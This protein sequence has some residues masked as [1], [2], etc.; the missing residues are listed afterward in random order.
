[1]LGFVHIWTQK[2]NKCFSL[3]ISQLVNYVSKIQQTLL[4]VDMKQSYTVDR[5]NLLYNKSFIYVFCFEVK[6]Y[7]ILRTQTYVAEVLVYAM[8]TEIFFFLVLIR[9]WLCL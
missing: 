3:H 4:Y 7:L 8:L 5:N 6:I 1:M 2:R 9:L